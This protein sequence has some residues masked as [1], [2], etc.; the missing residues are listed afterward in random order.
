MTVTDVQL[1]N[2]IGRFILISNAVFMVSLLLLYLLAG[3]TD[4]EFQSLLKMLAPVKAIYLTALVKYA[5]ANKHESTVADSG[6]PLSPLFSQASYYFIFGYMIALIF[7][8]WGYA[9]FNIVL[10]ETLE[11]LLATLETFFGVYVGLFIADIF[12]VDSK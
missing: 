7:I 2:R 10:F 12:K 4:Q 3:F 6:R 5:I 11:N 8:T 1:R 9:F